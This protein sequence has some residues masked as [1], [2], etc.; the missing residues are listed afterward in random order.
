MAV[1]ILP[2]SAMT[3][4]SEL[5][6]KLRH[7][8][9]RNA[10]L[11]L[12]GLFL[13]YAAAIAAMLVRQEAL[14]F[15]PVKLAAD[16]RFNKPDVIERQ[17]EVPGATL[18]ALHFR[19]PDAKGLIFFLHGNAGNLD[20][21]LPSTEF[22]RRAGYDLFMIDYRG[23][24]KSTGRIE[25]E[26]Q[27]HAD[28]RA[29]WN[30]ITPEYAGKPIVIYGRSLGS[31]LAVKLATEVD[32]AQL[33]L[34]SAYSSFV[35]LGRDHFPWVPSFATR[36]P[37][38]SDE[39]LA[40]VSEPILLIHGARDPLVNVKHSQQIKALRPEAELLILPEA[41]HNDVHEFP[42]YTK[43]LSAKL[44]ALAQSH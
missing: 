15:Y 42:A 35:Q 28:V 21:W 34:V 29:A 3:I 23:F 10:L 14:L 30:S 19:Q 36:Y 17:I 25:S 8:W 33:I 32:A 37:M 20:I 22:Y 43:A 27:L 9:L 26:A 6:G 41:S 13:L 7:V 39:W 38:R 31:G 24:G 40:Q 12:L 5:A 11:V 2:E 44:T 1:F 4:A 18:S 16:F